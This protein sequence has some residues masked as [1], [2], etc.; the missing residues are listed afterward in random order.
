M[1]GW[2]RRASGLAGVVLA[3]VILLGSAVES[4]AQQWNDGNFQETSHYFDCTIPP[5]PEYMTGV[6]SGFYGPRQ[7]G[8]IY[9]THVVLSTVGGVCESSDGYVAPE[10]S[11]PPN[12]TLAIS[13][14][15]P[16]YCF[17]YPPGG[18]SFQITAAQG[19]PV[20][21]NVYPVPTTYF[22][23]IPH[24]GAYGLAS[25]ITGTGPDS[26][27]GWW[28]LPTGAFLEIQ[29]PVI[30]SQPMSGTGY[31]TGYVTDKTTYAWTGSNEGV[32]VNP[33]NAPSDLIFKNGFESGNTSAW[34]SAVTASGSLTVR[35]DSA[36]RGSNYGLR[37]VANGVNPMYV[38]SDH[39]NNLNRYRGRFYFHPGNFDTGEASG[40]FRAVLFLGFNTTPTQRRIMSIELKRQAGLYYVR[41]SVRPDGG[42]LI[43]TPFV[44]IAGNTIHTVEFD[45]RR[46]TAPGANNGSLT[47]WVDDTSS[48]LTLSGIDNDTAG[49]DFARLG[50]MSPKPGA[51]GA[52]YLDEFESRTT[53]GMGP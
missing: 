44:P 24:R 16:I 45:F 40:H 4:R 26:Q 42:G 11:L 12:T 51:N 48:P 2:G 31:V 23:A 28:A 39:P 38:V 53:T 7:V 46:S 15:T 14:A 21:P 33:Y 9:Y 32:F 47:F 6:Y 8:D 52:Y 30:S 19:C 35:T 18:G 17:G 27:D 49:F 10:I 22:P 25:T 1:G 50:L 34:T 13:A 37:V 43:S 29:V 41:G 3:P 5:T 20:Y 36:M